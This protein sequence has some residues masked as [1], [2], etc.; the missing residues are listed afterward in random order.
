MATTGERP[1]DHL[2]YTLGTF[3]GR[4]HETAEIVALLATARLFTLTGT[5]GSGKTR[6]AAEV[7]C[8]VKDS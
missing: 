8:E 4:A 1:V 5:G 7:A 2:P 6:L 3:I